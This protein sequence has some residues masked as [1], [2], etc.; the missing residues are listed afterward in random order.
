MSISKNFFSAI[1]VLYDG[2]QNKRKCTEFKD[3][4]FTEEK[5]IVYDDSAPDACRL[6]ICYVKNSDGAFSPAEHIPE[7]GGYPV[8]FYIHGG[9]FMAG[10]KRYRRALSRWCA[11]IGYF[12]VNI[13]YGLAPKYRFPHPHRHTVAA[14]NWVERNAEKY[15]LDTSRMV[16]AGDS[17]GGY[18]AAM[19]ACICTH[20]EIQQKLGMST[21]VKFS[22]AWLNCAVYDMEL[23]AHSKLVLNLGARTFYDATGAKIEEIEDFAWRELCSVP[24]LVDK[25][26]PKSFITYAKKDVLCINQAD[27][28]LEALAKAG[29]YFE[30]YHTCT[31]VANHCFSL[32]W[33]GKFAEENN[34]LA[35]DFLKRF[36]DGKI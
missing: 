6:D 36:K 8:I 31:L 25:N 7:E 14:L 20:P 22:A 27:G 4:E 34:R 12:V 16:V 21:G 26:F 29:V 32:T 23:L 3:V 5:D 19:L 28:M 30:Q 2:A 10:D 17:A 24:A 33:K 35:A 13:N 15:N 18:Y 9:G 1:D 11:T